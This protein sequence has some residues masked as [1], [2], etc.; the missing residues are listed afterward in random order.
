MVVLQRSASHFPLLPVSSEEATRGGQQMQSEGECGEV[1][2]TAVLQVRQVS[3]ALKGSHQQTDP[4]GAEPFWTS[5]EQNPKV[6][7]SV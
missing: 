3:D 7:V 4:H 1:H 5:Q 6:R 2:D